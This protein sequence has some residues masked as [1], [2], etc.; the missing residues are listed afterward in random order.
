MGAKHALDVSSLLRPRLVKTKKKHNKCMRTFFEKRRKVFDF[1]FTQRRS[2][3]FALLMIEVH[4]KHWISILKKLIKEYILTNASLLRESSIYMSL[5]S[6]HRYEPLCNCLCYR[7]QLEWDRAMAKPCSRI[8]SRCLLDK[9]RYVDVRWVVM[10]AEC[11]IYW[12]L[13]SDLPEDCAERSGTVSFWSHPRLIGQTSQMEICFS[14]SLSGRH[15]FHG[16]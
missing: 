16:A 4:K 10:V 6:H 3:F 9:L 7:P 1:D 11:A 14:F 12:A 2:A 5:R 13:S 8:V 15:W